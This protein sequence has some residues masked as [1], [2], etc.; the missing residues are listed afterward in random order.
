MPLQNLQRRITAIKSFDLEAEQT[1]IIAGASTII[2]DVLSEQLSRGEDIRGQQRVDEYTPFTVRYKQQF[3]R[4][5]GRVVDRVTF[6]MTGTLYSSLVLS[7]RGRMGEI[8]SPLETYGKMVERIGRSNFG[9]SPSS[10][11]RVRNEI[12]RPRLRDVINGSGIGG[13]K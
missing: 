11:D 13:M 5:L 2:T 6:Y 8:T 12:V 3:G 4:G 9:F 1:A 7:I 10:R